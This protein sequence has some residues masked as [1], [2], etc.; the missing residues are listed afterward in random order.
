[1]AIKGA[2]EAL[3]R[4]SKILSN[5]SKFENIKAFNVASYKTLQTTSSKMGEPKLIKDIAS[6]NTRLLAGFDNSLFQNTQL[7]QDAMTLHWDTMAKLA[8]M[9]QTPE[10]ELLKKSLL[11]NQLEALTTFTQS[12]SKT[13]IDAANLSFLKMAKIFEGHDLGL[14]K[15]LPSIL[16]LIHVGTAEKLSKSNNICLDI[17]QKEF[18]IQNNPL[19]NATITET[20]VA[21]SALD[22]LPDIS[23]VEAIEFINQLE[24]NYAY[25]KDTPVGQKVE[26]IVSSWTPI[27]GFDCEHYYHGRPYGE[28]QLE[29]YKNSELGQAPINLTR[30]GRFNYIGESHYYFSNKSKGA[31]LEIKKHSAAEIAQVAKLKPNKTI[32]MV[33]FSGEVIGRNKFLE[34]CRVPYN[35][36]HAELTRHPEYLFPCYVASCCRVHNIDGIKYYGSKEYQNYVS[37]EDDYFDVVSSD[38][39]SLI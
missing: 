12:L 22:I 15:G 27:I 38:V 13:S 2:Y 10:I 14:P 4:I 39:V 21:L 31:E 33:D 35:P 30:H 8:Q 37:W 19:N 9:Y 28:G 24:R 32:R 29:P 20:N 25:A 1:M 7:V 18:Y 16:N 6:K 11:N 36:N 5:T 3:S 23:E 34:Y 26:A 17:Q